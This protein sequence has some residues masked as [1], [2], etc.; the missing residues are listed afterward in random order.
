MSFRNHRFNCISFTQAIRDESWRESNI[1]SQLRCCKG[2]PVKFYKNIFAGIVSLLHAGCPSAISFKV[3]AIII[4]AVNGMLR[5]WPGSHII[6]KILKLFPG[7]YNSSTAVTFKSWI[8]RIVTSL[9]HAPV[10][11]PFWQVAFAMGSCFTNQNFFFI[12]TAA[13]SIFTS[14][15]NSFNNNNL[16]AITLA[17]PAHAIFA[18]RKFYCTQSTKSLPFN[19]MTYFRHDHLRNGLLRENGRGSRHG[20]PTFGSD[21]SRV[22]SI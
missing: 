9:D 19:K 8:F 22:M 11:V 14:Q 20:A 21:P 1:S 18:W 13:T 3:W 16:A 15:I 6:P 17:Q 4:N 12:A 5:R 2:L 7:D 10:N